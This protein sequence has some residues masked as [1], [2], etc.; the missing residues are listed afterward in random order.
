M[1]VHVAWTR[2]KKV[3]VACINGVHINIPTDF[4]LSIRF[5]DIISQRGF[6]YGLVNSVLN[7][8]DAQVKFFGEFIFQNNG[9]QSCT[10]KKI[11]RLVKVTLG[12]VHSSY[13]L[14]EWQAVKLTFFAPGHSLHY[15]GCL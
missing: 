4:I 12:L 3:S 2:K 11:L 6:C 9:N 13:S 1:G 8:P 10:S 7:L 14:P 15:S 5:C